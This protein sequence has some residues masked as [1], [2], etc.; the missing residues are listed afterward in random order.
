M[1]VTRE[2]NIS[3]HPVD[4]SLTPIAIAAN[5][6]EYIA[7]QVMP[8]LA[9][10]QTQKFTWLKRKTNH[11]LG[12]GKDRTLVGRTSSV[13]LVDYESEEIEDKTQDFGVGTV[14]PDDDQHQAGAKGVDPAAE[15][16]EDLMH[17]VHTEREQRVR[18]IVFNPATYL[19]SQVEDLS[20][21]PGSQFRDPNSKPI[22][23]IEDLLNTM[24]YR[25]NTMV[26]GR[27]DFSVLRRHPQM[28]KAHHGNEGDAGMASLQT[29]ATLFGLRN[30]LVGPAFI[31]DDGAMGDL[32]NTSRIWD[33]GLALLHINPR[34]AGGSA[35]R[36]RLTFGATQPYRTPVAFR[37]FLDPGDAG[38]RGSW[39]IVAG[40][41]LKEF[42]SAN[43]LGAFIND[44]SGPAS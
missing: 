20:G 32:S 15:A 42:V 35:N 33:G 2:N 12:G 24:A 40:E 22:E 36:I 8:R 3:Q 38:L 11:A 34:A 25:A 43:F 5:Q 27:N 14:I 39:K 6:E 41:S 7:D 28:V 37:K 18:N 30:I 9:P 16:T 26:I 13:R 10:V 44:P 29:I 21:D 17:I 4:D 1:P 19:P 31:D 23:V